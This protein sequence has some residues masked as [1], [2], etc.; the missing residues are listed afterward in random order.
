MLL[1]KRSLKIIG[2]VGGV[3]LIVVIAL[4]IGGGD[5][6]TTITLDD[7]AS[8][9]IPQGAVGPNASVAAT[10][11]IPENG[12]E[13]PEGFTIETLYE[14][15]IDEPLMKPVTLRLPLT[16]VTED[17]VLWLAKYDEA[18]GAW[19]GVEFTIEDGYAV[20][21]TNTLSIFGTIKGTWDDFAHWATKKA[22]SVAS[23]ARDEILPRLTLDYWISW[24]EDIMGAD[25]MIYEPLFATSRELEYDDSGSADLI[26][27]SARV[28]GEELVEI[29]IENETKMYLHL[30]FDGPSVQPIKR[31]Y[32]A[33]TDALM[34]VETTPVMENLLRDSYSP[35]SVILLPESTADFHAYMKEGETLEIR[36]ELSNAAALFNSLDPFFALVP[37]VDAEAVSAVRD[38]K[39]AGSAFYEALVAYESEWRVKT[40]YGLNFIAE[41]LRTGWLFGTKASKM[42]AYK[43]LLGVPAVTELVDRSLERVEDIVDKGS[44]AIWGGTLVF[45]FGEGDTV[46]PEYNLTVSSTAGGSGTTPGEGT[47]VYDTGTVVSLV[48]TPASGYRFVNWT[49]DTGTLDNVNAT[50]TTI[51]MNSDYSIT[52]NF[53]EEEVV[54]PEYILMV[55]TGWSHTVGV[56]SDGTVAAVG[57]SGSGLCNVGGWT[58]IVQVAAGVGHTVGLKSD[59]TVVAVGSSDFARCNVGGWTDIVQVAA[60]G[61]HTVGLK[62]DGTV[63]AVG[64]NFWGQCNVVGWTDIVQVAAGGGHTV[65]LKSDGTV[66]SVGDDAYG[67]WNVVGW[68]DIIQV[69]AGDLHTV[70]V[71]SDGT[72]V[73]VGAKL[74]GQCTFVGWKDII[75]VAA[76]DMHTVGLKADGTVVATGYWAQGQL[77]VDGWMDII[78]VA[79]GGYHTVG[80]KSDGTVVA[81]GRNDRGQCDVGGWTLK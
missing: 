2:I 75:Q 50:S 46:E 56:K 65:G 25:K 55:A 31:G 74:F 40:Y 68:K 69:A 58:D 52:A 1:S 61:Y 47:S 70:G 8:I 11:L 78:Q 23:W 72:V 66:V 44:D 67:L 62:S 41:T 81:V 32:L 60:G 22:G 21:Q 73:A 9:S 18:D 26:S 6:G 4:L 64:S 53:E 63:V 15:S 13:V 37:I 57:C 43:A 49:G 51:T 54:E 38:V 19:H 42:V 59:G 27:A 28:M 36:A 30:Y 34:L 24:Y 33:L 79:A 17:S 80:V 71:K 29:R 16:S 12:P 20:V 10:M 39:G 5:E 3:V 77:N 7:G 76:G 45:K 14:F 48:A 35:Q